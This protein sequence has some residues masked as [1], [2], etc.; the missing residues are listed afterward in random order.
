MGSSVGFP[1]RVGP[2]SGR[3]GPRIELA[4][5]SIRFRTGTEAVQSVSLGVADGEFVAIVGPS[6]CGK[7][8]V[9]NAIAGLLD[10]VE[11]EQ[12][13]SIRLEGQAVLASDGKA[14]RGLGY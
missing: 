7:T 5:L 2:V 10:P 13:G 14:R 4:D 3:A 1:V 11:V 12:R 8:T 9:L 6:G